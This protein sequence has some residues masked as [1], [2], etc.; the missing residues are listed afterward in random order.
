I[1]AGKPAVL[2]VMM[3][4]VTGRTHVTI[5]VS[6]AVIG[7]K[8]KDIL[9]A[10]TPNVSRQLKEGDDPTAG[11]A[12]RTCGAANF[13]FTPP[14]GQWS[15]TVKVLDDSGTVADQQTLAVKSRTT[16][17]LLLKAVSVC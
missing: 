14:A 6:G 5:Q 11:A 3:G 15:V 12:T 10:C 2:R 4:Q 16:D 9:P 13:P 17:A 8:P 7:S 1:V